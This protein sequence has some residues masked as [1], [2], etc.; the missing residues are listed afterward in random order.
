MA[1]YTPIYSGG[2]V[3]FTATTSAIVN[4]GRVVKVSADGTVAHA[5]SAADTSC[6][7]V[8]ATDAPSGAK[9]AVWPLANCVH[10]LTALATITAGDGVVAAAGGA[11]A[12][13]TVATAAAAGTL[14]GV[15]TTTRTGAG[16]VRVMG[17]Y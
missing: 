3:P 11:V 10:E 6:L 9:V 12:T 15:A 7:G 16:T 13:A 8:A 17:R 2:V 5:A 4:A 14:I 1:D